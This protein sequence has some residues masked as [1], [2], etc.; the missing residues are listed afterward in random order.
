[1]Q[2]LTTLAPCAAHPCCQSSF[3]TSH[4]CHPSHRLLN[5]LAAILISV[6]AILLFAEIMPQALC[7]RYGL[8]IGAY[9]S[10]LV[11]LLMWITF[12]VSWPLGKVCACAG[13]VGAGLGREAGCSSD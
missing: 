10:W 8:E 12:P 3:G 2:A 4:S 13:R 9:C 5:P 7:K 6:T 1:M 11:R